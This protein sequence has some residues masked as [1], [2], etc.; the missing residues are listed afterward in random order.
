MALEKDSLTFENLGIV[1]TDLPSISMVII[2]RNEAKNLPNCIQ[3]IR[4]MEYPKDLYEVLY[5]DTDSC[6]GSPEIAR[7]ISVTVF[8]E[9]SN[10]P[11]SGRARNRGWQE[12]K[13]DIVHFVDGDMTVDPFYL[14]QAV[15][16]LKFDNV[17]CVIGKL[18]ELHSSHNFFSRIF[19]YPWKVKQT[20]FVDAPGAGGTFKKSVL[21]RVG[22]YKGNL[23]RGEEPE[24]GFRL[25]DLGYRILMIDHVMGTHDYGIHTIGELCVHFQRIGRNFANVLLLPPS[26][27]LAAERH[28]AQRS[29]IE[30]ILAIFVL[31]GMAYFYLWH[32]IPVLPILLA[33][34]VLARYWQPARLRYLRISYFM[35]DYFFK[36][37]VWFGMGKYLFTH[38]MQRR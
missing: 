34:Y 28:S 7:S 22:G 29:L 6:D 36:P 27:S 25:R 31:V 12:A 5:V 38:W 18:K 4:E 33:S 23:L 17:A 8:E 2:G 1:E 24:L 32:F 30:G 16:Y 37:V 13:Y 21:Q 19:E 14:K 20:G 10:L 35:L 15:R 3:S 9:R 26:T 11:T